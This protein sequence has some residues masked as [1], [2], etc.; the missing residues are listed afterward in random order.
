MSHRHWYC[1]HTWWWTNQNHSAC[2]RGSKWWKSPIRGRSQTSPWRT[3]P[4]PRRCPSP[5]YKPPPAQLDHRAFWSERFYRTFLPPITR[6]ERQPVTHHRLTHTD[7]R[8]QSDLEEML[9][10][11]DISDS[12]FWEERGW[13][14]SRQT[15]LGKVCSGSL[16]SA[17]SGR[18]L[19]LWFLVHGWCSVC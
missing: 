4:P 16:Q 19:G 18:W 11:P 15:S 14:S 9:C 12:G 6:S 7:I 5:H 2:E 13:P 8:R 1:S 17:G 3:A 10:W